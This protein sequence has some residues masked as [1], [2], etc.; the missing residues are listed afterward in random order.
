MTASNRE[1]AISITLGYEGGYTNDKADPGGPTNWGIT[2]WD[3]RM[4]WKENATAE[5]VKAMPKA[6]AIDIYH[7]KYWAKM[8]ND[9]DPAGVDLV[10]FDYGVNSGVGRAIPVRNKTKVEGDAVA[11][12]KA[13]C[14]ERLRFVHQIK[15]FS[16]FGRG[17]TRRIA[18]VEARGIKMASMARGNTKG[19]A[20]SGLKVE[21]QK[22]EDISKKAGA[23][24]T[25]T[26][27]VPATQTIDTP[28]TFD[29]SGINEYAIYA[30]I[31]VIVVVVI[32]FFYK[33]SVNKT[34]AEQLRKVA[35]E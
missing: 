11:W 8:K 14:A 15:T 29:Y 35:A 7:Q 5:D 6:V 31:A 13:I 3:A 30:G 22:A 12:V 16:V 27:A 28:L 33:Y 34:R 1:A 25:A 26:A 9:D 21:A 10:T 4:Y 23:A 20:N 32:G 24:G 2:I 19:M 18:D 17:W